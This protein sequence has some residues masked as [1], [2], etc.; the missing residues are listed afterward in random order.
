MSNLSAKFTSE[1]SYRQCMIPFLNKL[2]ALLSV[3]TLLLA[4]PPQI[5]STVPSLT[6]GDPVPVSWDRLL[7]QSRSGGHLLAKTIQHSYL[8][9]GQ[10]VQAAQGRAL[11]CSRTDA[12]WDSFWGVWWANRLLGRPLSWAHQ[13][14]MGTG[15]ISSH[16][17]QSQW[18]NQRLWMGFWGNF[19]LHT[20]GT[21]RAEGQAQGR[22]G[23][24][25]R[26]AYPWHMLAS[27]QEK[28]QLCLRDL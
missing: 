19:G 16:I 17:L 3:C 23:G 24:A 18:K 12:A 13:A 4:V 20:V 22:K 21:G 28:A 6:L 10:S 5:L 7:V 11:S 9:K 27:F 1:H 8:E 2:P 15:D 26:T 14:L 25:S